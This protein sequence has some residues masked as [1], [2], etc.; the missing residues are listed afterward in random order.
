MYRS[1]RRSAAIRL[2]ASMTVALRLM[3]AVDSSA[4]ETIPAGASGVEFRSAPPLAV[5]A[6][7]RQLADVL[8]RFGFTGRVESTLEQRLGRRIDLKLADLGRLIWFDT[9]V[10]LNNDNTCAGCHSPTN[11]FG[12]T[13]SIAI[14]IDNNAVVGPHRS[15]PRNQRRSP[16][17][18]NAALYPNLMWNSRFASLSNDPFDNSAGFAFPPPEGL[19]LSRLPHLLAAQAFI[20]PT[21][22]NEA[23]GFVFPGDNFAIRA[24]VLRRLNATP[25]YR[26]KF[27]QSFPEVKAG[28]PITFDMFGVAIAEFE[29][30]LVF[31]DAPLDRFARG[32]SRAMTT[33]Q[34]KG[35]VLFFGKA[36]CVNCHAV[37]GAS[38]EMFSDFETHVISVPQIVPAVTNSVFDGPGASEDFGL[39]QVTGRETDRYKFR[40]SPLRNLAVMPAFM[41]NG[42]FTTID[43]AVQHHLD[44]FASAR[45][46]R[47]D[48]LDTDLQG[49]LGPIEPV[50]ERVDPLLITP[51]TLSN[52]EFRQLVD[53]LRDGL[54]DPRA[55]PENLRSLVPDR[56]PSGRQVLT[57]E[58]EEPR[59][60]SAT[61]RREVTTDGEALAPSSPDATV[62]SSAFRIYAPRPNPA[63]GPVWFAIDLPHAGPV[64]AFLFDATGRRVR[65][66]AEG[67]PFEAGPNALE[68]DGRNDAGAR[69]AVGI[70][71]IRVRS[72]TG[73]G[74]QRFVYLGH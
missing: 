7:D 48:R 18:I 37:S 69:A 13:Q 1:L 46:Y 73:E 8:R 57:F 51:I 47:P 26:M 70:Y 52:I 43:E 31:A 39:E 12:D 23:A 27:G 4:T 45:D 24:E 54:L 61:S 63:S 74:A 44:V 14:G 9:L 40:T 32:R 60:A 15:G 29:L 25:S 64:S 5:S 2:L 34:K 55:L 72:E 21:E 28:A 53:F 30:T 58:F 59:R 33:S 19:T 41:H 17:A 42:C 67:R 49:A 3:L 56:V 35:A 10:G 38:N 6:I 66:L 36:G 50:L 62:A 65:T 22:R 71:F 20:P 16:V 68:W 11:G